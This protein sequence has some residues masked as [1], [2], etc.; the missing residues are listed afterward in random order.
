MMGAALWVAAALYVFVLRSGEYCEDAG[1]CEDGALLPALAQMG[2]AIAGGVAAVQVG[3]RL[4]RFSREAERPTDVVNRTLV[5]GGCGA[6]WLIVV[7]SLRF[8]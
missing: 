5:A 2:L 8:P 6:L 7:A 1:V 4:L 3:S